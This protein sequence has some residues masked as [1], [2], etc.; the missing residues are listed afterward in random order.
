VIVSTYTMHGTP[1]SMLRMEAECSSEELAST[2]QNLTIILRECFSP[3]LLYLP[4][5]ESV[6]C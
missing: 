3:K 4:S 1:N 2:N 6:P 5:G